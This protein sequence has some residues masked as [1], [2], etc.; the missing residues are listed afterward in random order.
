M[1]MFILAVI[2]IIAVA[3]I[4]TGMWKARTI[5]AEKIT[6]LTID[7]DYYSNAYHLLRRATHKEVTDSG[8]VRPFADRSGV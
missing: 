2:G 3:L 5:D 8:K 6:A 4:Q 7:K 1:G